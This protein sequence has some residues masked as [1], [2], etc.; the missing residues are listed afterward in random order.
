MEE[1]LKKDTPTAWS[2]SN[3]MGFRVT[4]PWVQILALSVSSCVTQGKLLSSFMP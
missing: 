3:N 4:Q 1:A 2:N